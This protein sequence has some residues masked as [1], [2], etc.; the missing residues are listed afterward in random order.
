LL[1]WLEGVALAVSSTA[2]SE[3][4]LPNTPLIQSVLRNYNPRRSGDIFVVIQ[5]HYFVNEED[6][7]IVTSTHGSPRRY[8]TFVPIVFAGGKLTAR[9][10]YRSIETV[11]VAP[12]LAAI[13]GAKPPSGARNGPLPEVMHGFA[14]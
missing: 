10:V 11:D 14:E 6:G 13:I 7:L 3:G 12:T 9:H 2:L 5:P 8:D 4:N 1:C